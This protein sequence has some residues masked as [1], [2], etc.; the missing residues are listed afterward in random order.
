MLTKQTVFP[1]AHYNISEIC[2]ELCE[3]LWYRYLLIGRPLGFRSLWIILNFCNSDK[4]STTSLHICNL[5]KLY[6]TCLFLITLRSQVVPHQ[7]GIYLWKFLSCLDVVSFVQIFFF[8][9]PILRHLLLSSMWRWKFK[10][11]LSRLT[12]IYK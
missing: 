6:W 4:P 11:T 2:Q 5:L 9:Q 8:V 3:E 7:W 10:T 12:Q 1:F